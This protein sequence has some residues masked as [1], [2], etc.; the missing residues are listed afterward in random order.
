MLLLLLHH[1]RRVGIFKRLEN[2]G[3]EQ[4]VADVVQL[5]LRLVEILVQA[6]VRRFRPSPLNC[7]SA[8]KRPVSFSASLQKCPS[9]TPE[10]RRDSTIQLA[11]AKP[12]GARKIVVEQQKFRNQT[13]M[14]LARRRMVL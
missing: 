4:R 7:S 9:A 14:H 1:V 12:D 10:M 2:V 3:A 8:R 13:R 6:D 5:D 11:D